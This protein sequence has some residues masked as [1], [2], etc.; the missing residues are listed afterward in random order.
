MR[1]ALNARDNDMVP[2]MID[3]SEIIIVKSGT[4]ATV[5]EIN[6]PFARIRIRT[7]PSKGYIGYI[8]LTDLYPVKKQIPPSPL[9]RGPG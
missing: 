9:K 7:G 5:L 6:E 1:T 2:E 8:E 3:R 4:Q